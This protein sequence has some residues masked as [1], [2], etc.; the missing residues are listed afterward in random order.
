MRL[1]E[2]LQSSRRKGSKATFKTQSK[3]E[4]LNAVLSEHFHRHGKVASSTR[5]L[6]FCNTR[7]TVADIVRE[8]SK[9]KCRHIYVIELIFI[10]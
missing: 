8:I 5:A 3:L 6:I 1:I 4:H 9:A 2:T 10:E 7:D